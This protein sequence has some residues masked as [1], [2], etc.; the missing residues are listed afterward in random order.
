MIA[1]LPPDDRPQLGEDIIEPSK[2]DFVDDV[3]DDAFMGEAWEYVRT[4]SYK[5]EEAVAKYV[6]N[7][8]TRRSMN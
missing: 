7:I 5:V 1:M 2:K 6:A 4:L 3:D 8:Q